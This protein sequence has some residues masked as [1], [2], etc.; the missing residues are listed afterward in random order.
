MGLN[1]MTKI[2]LR[3]LKFELRHTG[4]MSCKGSGSLSSLSTKAG[5]IAINRGEV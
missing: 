1:P 4:K 3:R 5:S 2:F